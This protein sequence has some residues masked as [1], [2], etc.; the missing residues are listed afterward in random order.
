MNAAKTT[1][2][3]AQAVVRAL[4]LLKLFHDSPG[5]APSLSI[6]EIR[7]RVDLNRSTVLRLLGALESEG[8]LAR[9]PVTDH[10]RLGPEIAALGRRAGG[11]DD[12]RTLA[13]PEME[14]LQERTGETVTLET[15]VGNEALIVAEAL[16]DHVLG[17]HPSEGTTWPAH[18]TSTGKVLL[19]GLDEE[20]RARLLTGRLRRMTE[21]TITTKS[22]LEAELARVERRRR[23]L[24]LEELELGF[25]ALAVPV[26]D[27]GGRVVAALSVGGPSQ[28]LSPRRLE[29]FAAELTRAAGRITSAL[30]GRREDAR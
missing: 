28:R 27:A 11:V 25:V 15:L 4:R 16:G 10:Y 19:A 20:A 22:A 29:S 7:A 21:H 17:A 2:P 14:R 1:Y 13:R 24:S 30:S 9:D 6:T 26:H 8:M 12:L 18:A 3:G 5:S 23:A